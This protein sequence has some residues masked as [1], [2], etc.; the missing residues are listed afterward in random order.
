MI[1]CS[2]GAAPKAMIEANSVCA[3]VRPSRSKT[4]VTRSPISL[5]IG[6]REERMSTVAISRETATTR[7]CST[8]ARMGSAVWDTGRLEDVDAERD[9]ET[10]S[11]PPGVTM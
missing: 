1:A 3:S 5:K 4:T 6:E 9:L 2:D 10:A 8:E 11:P 7:R